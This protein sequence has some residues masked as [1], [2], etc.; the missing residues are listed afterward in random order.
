MAAS[1]TFNIIGSKIPKHC[2]QSFSTSTCIQNKWRL[3][4]GLE[5]NTTSYSPL[6][7]LPD[8]SFVDGRP[9]ILS[10]RKVQ[11]LERE[12]QICEKISR[13]SNELDVGLKNY[14]EKQKEIE[15]RKQKILDNKLKPKGKSL[16][17]KL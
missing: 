7:K 1:R 9:I 16:L 17:K 11:L 12:K 15:N 13:L 5:Q 8:Y 2:K 3:Q 4:N 10:W 6:T 14:Y